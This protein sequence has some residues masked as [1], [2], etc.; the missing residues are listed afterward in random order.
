MGGPSTSPAF[1]QDKKN[2]GTNFPCRI[3]TPPLPLLLLR[4]ASDHSALLLWGTHE[5]KQQR[6]QRKDIAFLSSPSSPFYPTHPGKE[7]YRVC[8]KNFEQ[9]FNNL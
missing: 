2:N 1:P 8:Y 6:C 3:I 9:Q 4:P 5:G 7:R